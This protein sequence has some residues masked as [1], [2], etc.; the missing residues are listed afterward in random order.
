VQYVEHT[1]QL[2]RRKDYGTAAVVRDP[3]AFLLSMDANEDE[4]KCTG[5]LLC[6]HGKFIPGQYPQQ[7]ECEILGRVEERLDCPHFQGQPIMNRL[8]Q[9]AERPP[10]AENDNVIVAETLHKARATLAKYSMPKPI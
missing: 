9:Q 10:P 1:R 8:E 5:C 6:I 4:D 7:V 3:S 2:F